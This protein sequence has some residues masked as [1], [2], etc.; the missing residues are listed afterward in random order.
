MSNPTK[1]MSQRYL[2]DG[3]ITLPGGQ[4]DGVS[5]LLAD[6]SQYV[7]GLNVSTRS[8]LLHTRPKFKEMDLLDSNGDPWTLPDGKFQGAFTYS[9]NGGDRIVVGIAGVLYSIYINVTGQT[10]FTVHSHYMGGA[11]FNSEAD[12]IYFCQA[13]RYL[14]VQDGTSDPV[15]IYEKISL[16]V[17][18]DVA[19]QFTP[20]YT[21][22]EIILDEEGVDTGLGTPPP[23]YE[24]SGGRLPVGTIMAYGYGR[25]FVVPRYVPDTEPANSIS[26]KPYWLASDIIKADNPIE[27]LWYTEV[28]YLAG[29]GA[30]ASPIEAGYVGGMQLT[31][32]MLSGDGNGPLIVFYRS[33]VSSF[34]VQASEEQWTIITIGNVLF[35]TAGSVSPR[36]CISMNSDLLFRST[37][38]IRTIKSDVTQAGS[39]TLA[40][41][42]ISNRVKRI[43]DED[44]GEALPYVSA[45]VVDNRMLMTTNNAIEGGDPVFNGIVS[46]DVASY[47]SADNNTTPIFDGIWTGLKFLQVLTARST[48]LDFHAFAFTKSGESNSLWR[49]AKDEAEYLDGEDSRPLCR[50]YTTPVLWEE[51]FVVKDLKCI[52][53]WISDI[54]GEVDVKI[55]YRPYGFKLWN[56]TNSG[57]FEAD[58]VTDGSL[59]QRRWKR[60]FIIA[61]EP[62][63]DLENNMV[64]RS[65]IFEFCIEWQGHMEINRVLFQ[66]KDLHTSY[67]DVCTDEVAVPLIAGARGSLIDDTTYEIGV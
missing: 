16:S 4:N 37:D 59:P 23:G 34:S 65:A 19:V 12:M 61:D 21:E 36:A 20:T 28:S 3:F 62:I 24:D 8:G 15:A 40:N 63:C 10:A 13:D 48:L 38:G 7:K 55:Y 27:V 33:G 18:R 41:V 51:F 67:N 5:P 47:Q 1:D 45:C 22:G 49:L 2:H 56:E 53:M 54:Q 64:D 46:Y 32:N 58:M 60:R 35:T 52:D 57:H 66:S 39:G 14:A 43:L 26:G 25:L 30:T 29:G 17:H 6:K 50:V 44:S 11:V 31:R 9:L 42:T